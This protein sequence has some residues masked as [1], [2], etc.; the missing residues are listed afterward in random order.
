MD[1]TMNK[2]IILLTLLITFTS[3]SQSCYNKYGSSSKEIHKT[4]YRY[5]R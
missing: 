4:M 2:L 5:A 3:C 1:G